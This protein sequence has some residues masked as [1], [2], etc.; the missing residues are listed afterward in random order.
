MPMRFSKKLLAVLQELDASAEEPRIGPAL[1]EIVSEHATNDEEAVKLVKRL[2]EL[3][4]LFR[5]R[6]AIG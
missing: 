3:A 5:E 1:A 4:R 6:M 2:E